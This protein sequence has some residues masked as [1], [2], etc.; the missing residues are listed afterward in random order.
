VRFGDQP[1]LAVF[2]GDS[3]SP[4][5]QDRIYLELAPAKH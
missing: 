1:K 3:V 2:V 4:D 5:D